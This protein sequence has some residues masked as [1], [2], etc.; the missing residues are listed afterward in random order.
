MRRSIDYHPETKSARGSANKLLV[1]HTLCSSI[2]LHRISC[3]RASEETFQTVG[4]GF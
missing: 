3:V 2:V 4:F 1:N